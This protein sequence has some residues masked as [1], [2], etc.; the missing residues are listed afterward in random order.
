[1]QHHYGGEIL[2][3]LPEAWQHEKGQKH[4]LFIE[5]DTRDWDFPESSWEEASFHHQGVVEVGP[6]LTP[7]VKSADGLIEG[8][9]DFSRKFVAGFQWH[10]EKEGS[11]TDEIILDRFVHCCSES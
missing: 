7:L 2:R 1:M 9:V 3:H 8:F 10:V 11:K 4:E 6:F 5:N